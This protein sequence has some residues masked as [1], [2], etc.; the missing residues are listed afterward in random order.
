MYTRRIVLAGLIL[1]CALGGTTA[2][3]A[4]M[5]CPAAPLMTYI[6]GGFA[7]TED[8]GAVTFQSFVFTPPQIGLNASQIMV[9]P[10]TVPG[11]AGF[12][13]VG[14][15]MVPAGQNAT[16]VL[17]YF[18]DPPPIIHGEQIDLDPIM[19]VSLQTDL[20]ITPFPCAG[21]NSLGTLNASTTTSLMASMALSPTGALGV[22]NTLTL[23]GAANGAS[24]QGFDNITFIAHE[25]SSI[26]L[27]ACGLLILLVFPS[28]AKLRRFRF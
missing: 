28:H 18:V 11:E 5:Q 12:L 4:P 17:S 24:S 1:L 20:C 26:L 9:N 25:P 23:T 3:A 13:F 19:F 8:G 10:V 7:C 16:Y 15:F 22:Q 6:S 27:A 2:L 21:G 14:N